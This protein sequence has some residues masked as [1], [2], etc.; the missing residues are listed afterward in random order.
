VCAYLQ[1]VEVQIEDKSQGVRFPAFLDRVRER[2]RERER[3]K[4]RERERER[5]RE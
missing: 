4:E 1:E 2:E 5:E 3:E